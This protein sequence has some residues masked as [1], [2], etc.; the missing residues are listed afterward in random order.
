MTPLRRVTAGIVVTL[1]L[2]AS[3]VACA[4][5]LDIAG[6]GGSATRGNT[7][8]AEP[9]DTGM[10][11]STTTP[12]PTP[13]QTLTAPDDVDT[14]TLTTPTRTTVI[15]D[16]EGTPTLCVGLQQSSLPPGCGGVDL[17]GWDW[18]DLAGT[19]EELGGVRWGDFS[20]SGEYSRA[21]NALWVTR[22]TP[23]GTD[24]GH[25]WAYCSGEGRTEGVPPADPKAVWSY[26]VQEM[27]VEVYL[28]ETDRPCGVARVLVAFDNGSI[29]N[30]VDKR[31]GAGAAQVV[32]GLA[33]ITG[34]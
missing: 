25:A 18:S 13:G 31:F 34:Q 10:R 24:L 26:I 15:D 8:S 20:V 28:A 22:A 21:H 17:I 3:G 14:V 4:A 7:T 16:G 33:A 6:D 30:A 12:S 11:S 19:Y 29:Q 1:V 23:D 27:G 32:S 9:R 5:P 2:A